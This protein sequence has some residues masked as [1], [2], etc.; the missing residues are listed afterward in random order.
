M[1]AKAKN[2]TGWSRDFVTWL[3]GSQKLELLRSP[4]TGQLSKPNEA[5]RDFR[6][7]MQQ[8]AREQRDEVTDTLRKKYAVKIAALQEKVR[9]AQQAVDRETA[10]SKQA[11]MQTA[12]SFGATLLG[13]FTGRKIASAGNLGRASTAMRSASRSMAQK[14]D[15]DRAKETVATYQKQLD[16]LNAQ[17]KE[18]ADA[19]ESKIDP[20]TEVLD[21]VTILPKKTDITVQLVSLVW[22]P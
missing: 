2:Y 7:R 12:I 18:E 3:Y 4:S 15:I 10:Q 11:G 19:M 1:A 9:K 14:A 6:V 20:A 16:D 8:A 21:A 5:E 13:A 17:F 22:M